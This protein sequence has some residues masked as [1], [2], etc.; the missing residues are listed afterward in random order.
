MRSFSFPGTYEDDAGVETV[1]WRIVSTWSPGWWPGYAVITV[2]RAVRVRGGD[3]DTL[4]PQDRAAA[5]GVLT[6]DRGGLT[7]CVLSGEL[8]ATL[9][10][11]EGIRSTSLRF[12]LDL[13]RATPGLRRPRHVL[14]LSCVLDGLERAVTDDWF[15]D[16][17]LS[18]EAAL[19]PGL[20]LRACI[21]CLYGGYSPDGHGLSGMRCHRD[22]KEQYLSV[23]SAEEYWHVPVT[24]DVL[25]T[26]LC[27][28]YERRVAGAETGTDAR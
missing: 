21:T 24:E 27:P 25:E 3:F 17:L 16:G 14:R 22:A 7:E 8:P 1:R 4:L 28:E 6:W 5:E 20:C 15:E 12:E 19:P 26:Y 13:R 18:L 2:I 10:S 9:Q 23:R 11:D